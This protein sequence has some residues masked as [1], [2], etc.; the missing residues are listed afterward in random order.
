[1]GSPKVKKRF[2][3]W[4]EYGEGHSMCVQNSMCKGRHGC[5]WKPGLPSKVQAQEVHPQDIRGAWMQ[6]HIGESYSELRQTW[7]HILV[8]WPWGIF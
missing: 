2:V 1:M 7:I 8:V 3:L 5:M 6:L 4:M